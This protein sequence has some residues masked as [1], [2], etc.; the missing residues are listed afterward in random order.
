MDA[1]YC[2]QNIWFFKHCEWPPDGMCSFRLDNLADPPEDQKDQHRHLGP[3]PHVGCV[4]AWP[5]GVDPLGVND[6]RF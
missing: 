4:D 2:E 6:S 1:Q 5:F 3:Q